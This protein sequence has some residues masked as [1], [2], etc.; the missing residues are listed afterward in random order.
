LLEG[1]AAAARLPVPP[2]P[3]PLRPA[4]VDLGLAH[5][6]DWHPLL[7]ALL[8]DRAAGV[9]AAAIALGFHR[10]LMAAAVGWAQQAAQRQPRAGGHAPVVVLCGGCFQNRLLLDGTRRGLRRAGLEPLW[11]QQLPSGDGGLALGQLLA[12]RISSGG[13]AAPGAGVSAL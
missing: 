12:A 1:A 6:W 3:L 4:S 8:A 13:A 2:Y 9:P 5:W 11:A 7:T 10:A